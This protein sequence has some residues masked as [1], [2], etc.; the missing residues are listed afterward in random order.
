MAT[1][2]VKKYVKEHGEL[3]EGWLYKA[4]RLHIIRELSIE[5]KVEGVE[6]IYP[7]DIVD[8]A[9]QHKICVDVLNE[10]YGIAYGVSK[11]GKYNQL[12]TEIHL[13]VSVFQETIKGLA[14]KPE[15]PLSWSNLISEDDIYFPLT[16][17]SLAN[18]VYVYENH[19]DYSFRFCK[20]A[21]ITKRSFDNSKAKE[22]CV[23]DKVLED[24]AD[25]LSFRNAIDL[26]YIK[27]AGVVSECVFDK[28]APNLNNH[29]K[30]F[31]DKEACASYH[32]VGVHD[33]ILPN[34]IVD[35][36]STKMN[37]LVSKAQE[38][39]DVLSKTLE[40][41]KAL[42]DSIVEA[43]ASGGLED[44]YYGKLIEHLTQSIPLYINS[45]DERAKDIARRLAKKHYY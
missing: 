44:L 38:Q 11:R 13:D 40:Q 8:L 37:A 42:R 28:P 31:G 24:H 27:E 2:R 5:Y 10:H 14:V 3:V 33:D 43:E 22:L 34:G 25:N 23:I 7:Y 35:L 39:V 30:M 21:R 1:A 26:F 17:L 19:K 9:N 4:I 36:N 16:H 45:T 12:I 18:L 6:E 20:N 29:A 41:L 15:I 32:F